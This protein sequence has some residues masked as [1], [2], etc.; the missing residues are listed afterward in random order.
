[1]VGVS[2]P[3][4]VSFSVLRNLLKLRTRCIRAM[5]FAASGR[6]LGAACAGLLFASVSSQASFAAP[7]SDGQ[8]DS[9]S[10]ASA[11]EEKHV[12]AGRASMSADLPHS[13]RKKIDGAVLTK[14]SLKADAQVVTEGWLRAYATEA[15]PPDL[16]LAVPAYYESALESE[17]RAAIEEMLT[18]RGVETVEDPETTPYRLTYSAEVRTPEGNKGLPQSRL[19][20]AP[21]SEN[22]LD[23]GAQRLLA[24][25]DSFRPGVALGPAPETIVRGPALRISIYVVNGDERVWSGFAEAALGDNRRGDVARV[26]TSGLMRHWG[27]NA[28]FD[29]AHF[30]T[31]PGVTLPLNDIPDNE[32]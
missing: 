10:Q 30:S 2:R 23:L 5:F 20:I 26:L 1:M 31:G 22:R 32:F 27:E 3:L 15:L 7:D 13:P 29:N 12:E 9:E 8:S 4:S 25:S 18:Q 19:R 17:L 16:L 28:E 24:P 6:A 21:D 14:P 11:A